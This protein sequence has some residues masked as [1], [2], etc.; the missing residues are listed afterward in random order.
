MVVDCQQC[1]DNTVKDITPFP[2]QDQIQMDVAQAKFCSKIDL[3]NA[4]KQ[5]HIEPEDIYKTAFATVYGTCKINV[6]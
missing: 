4:Y 1:N 3:S 6:L 5:V 2:D